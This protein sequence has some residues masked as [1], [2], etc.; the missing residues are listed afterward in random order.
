MKLSLIYI[1]SL[2]ATLTFSI[3]ITPLMRYISLRLKIFDLPNTDVKTHTEP[4]P[5]FGG[6][7]V[8]LSI[9]ITMVL[10]RLI[11]NFPTGTL[12]ALRGFIFGSIPLIVLGIIDDLHIKGIRKNHTV[13]K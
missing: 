12:H 1:F 3:A 11:T 13:F 6:L 4:V 9:M 7:S 5:Y 10:L 8:W 2:L